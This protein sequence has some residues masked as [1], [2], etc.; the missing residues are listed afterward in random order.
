MKKPNHEKCREKAKEMVC[1]DC[2]E[3]YEWNAKTWVF[4]CDCRFGLT[5]ETVQYA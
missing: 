4:E 5:W 3:Q 1:D 2:G